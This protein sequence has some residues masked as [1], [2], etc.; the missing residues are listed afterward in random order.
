MQRDANAEDSPPRLD[1]LSP[2]RKAEIFDA[3]MQDV[4]TIIET[5]QWYEILR[6]S[7]MTKQEMIQ[8]GVNLPELKVTEAGIEAMVAHV[9]EKVRTTELE[10]GQTDVVIPIEELNAIAQID[11]RMSQLAEDAFLE[12]L[13][14]HPEILEAEVHRDQM[15]IAPAEQAYGFGLNFTAQEW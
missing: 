11:V 9:L 3:L 15:Y 2:E 13:Y 7:G 10:D 14:S 5:G 8:T 12:S 6:D 4:P 1:D